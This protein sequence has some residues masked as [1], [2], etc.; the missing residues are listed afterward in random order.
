MKEID[1]KKE[2]DTY[3][4]K[5]GEFR[6]VDI[7]EMRYLAIDGHMV[8]STT[9]ST[10]ATFVGWHPRSAVRFSASRFVELRTSERNARCRRL[11]LNVSCADAVEQ[12]V[13][14]LRAPSPVRGNDQDPA[15]RTG[16]ARGPEQRQR[17][18]RPRWSC[19]NTSRKLRT[20]RRRG[21]R[22]SRRVGFRQPFCLFDNQQPTTNN[23]QP[24]T[25]SQQSTMQHSPL[26]TC[27]RPAAL[28]A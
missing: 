22:T 12:A 9:R 26:S 18:I 19:S 25:N 20:G 16:A 17:S 4:A 14:A 8:A 21:N 6:T 23:Q 2:L 27:R 24:T 1:F 5:L 11:C 3:R 28:G 10:S 7:P 13:A 15:N